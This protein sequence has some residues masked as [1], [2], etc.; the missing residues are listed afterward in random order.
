[1]HGSFNVVPNG[2]NFDLVYDATEIPSGVLVS[3]LAEPLRYATPIGNNPNP[4]AP[5]EGEGQPWYWGAQKFTNDGQPHQLVSIGAKIGGGSTE[6]A[7]VVVAELRADS[8]GVMGDLIA[9]LSAPDLSGDIAG[10]EL[11][12][13]AAVTLTPGADYWVLLGSQSPGD[14]TYFWQYANSNFAVGSG[15]LGNYADSNDSGA[16]WVYRSVDFPYFLQVN[17]ADV[18]PP[19]ADFDGDG[20]V[21]GADL[22]R[23]QVGFGMAEGALLEQGDADVDGDIDGADFLA[24]QR[25]LGG[26]AASAAS[27]VVPEPASFGIVL[28]GALALRLRRRVGSGQ[29][30]RA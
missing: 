22:A 15:T 26:G 24:W 17:V 23:W 11:T 30:S 14:G 16:T 9:T 20:V 12:P 19:V 6:P 5:P 27:S 21:D 18:A 3:N 7:P 28:S 4:V 13:D 1:M 10:R 25:Q 29:R 2:G 8:G